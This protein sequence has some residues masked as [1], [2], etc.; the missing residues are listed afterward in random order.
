MNCVSVALTL[1]LLWGRSFATGEIDVT[2]ENFNVTYTSYKS[3]AAT[4]G[5]A[6]PDDGLSGRAVRSNP[7]NACRSIQPPPDEAPIA[8]DPSS[9]RWVVVIR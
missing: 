8:G 9:H 3:R 1:I 6:F 2:D 4:F 7:D 5:Q